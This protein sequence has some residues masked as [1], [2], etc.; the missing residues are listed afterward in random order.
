MNNTSQQTSQ[1]RSVET[2]FQL[3]VAA[4]DQDAF[5]DAEWKEI[6]AL[7]FTQVQRQIDQKLNQKLQFINHLSAK[8]QKLYEEWSQIEDIAKK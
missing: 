5:T 7:F 8:L 6:T 3:K 1:L 4:I 2:L